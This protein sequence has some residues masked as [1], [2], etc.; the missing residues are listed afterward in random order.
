MEVY[1]DAPDSVESLEARLFQAYTYTSSVLSLCQS[2]V[3]CK[4]FH[5]LSRRGLTLGCQLT[6]LSR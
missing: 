5:Y 4:F 3:R 1:I 6:I 2:R